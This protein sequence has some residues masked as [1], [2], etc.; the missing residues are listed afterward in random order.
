MK[1][2]ICC[3]LVPPLC[4]FCATVLC[5][6]YVVMMEACGMTGENNER[7]LCAGFVSGVVIFCTIL[8]LRAMRRNKS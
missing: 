3:V 7:V 2:I 8:L 1:K 4:V 6:C 5:A